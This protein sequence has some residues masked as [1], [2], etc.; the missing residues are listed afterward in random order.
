MTSLKCPTKLLQRDAHNTMFF[1]FSLGTRE[2]GKG[3]KVIPEIAKG[4]V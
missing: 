1:S 4:F 3:L 2:S